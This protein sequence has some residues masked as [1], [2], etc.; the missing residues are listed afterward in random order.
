MFVNELCRAI[1]VQRMVASPISTS[2]PDQ[3]KYKSE[4]K[5]PKL[6]SVSQIEAT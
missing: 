1:K 6:R 4:G 5:F 2:G 3:D